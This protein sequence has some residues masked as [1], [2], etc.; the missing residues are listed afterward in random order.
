MD[1]IVGDREIFNIAVDRKSFAA[2]GRSVIDFVTAN[3][4]IVDRCGCLRAIHG[5]S[6][7]IC[8]ATFGGGRNIVDVIVR[9]MKVATR[10][11]NVNSDGH[12]CS[13]RSG[14]IS[15]LETVDD[16]VALRFDGNKTPLGV[17]DRKPGSVDDG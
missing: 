8:G 14:I 11:E 5:H 1:Q 10:T 4:Q 12:V 15:N 16:D 13:F 7:G 6:K 3:D 2:A 17:R 9:D